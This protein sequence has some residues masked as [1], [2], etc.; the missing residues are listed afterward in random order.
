MYMCVSLYMY[1]YIPVNAVEA[2][3]S[4][5][6]CDGL[7]SEIR[8]AGIRGRDDSSAL[9]LFSGDDKARFYKQRVIR[10][11]HCPLFLSFCASLSVSLSLARACNSSRGT[12]DEPAL[13]SSRESESRFAIDE[14]RI[15]YER[16]LL[17]FRGVRVT[18][19]GKMHFL[20]ACRVGHTSHET[21]DK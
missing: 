3:C 5:R 1:I 15:N 20:Y 17:T 16:T 18:A 7:S 4:R 6:T 11:W 13:K 2:V 9:L 21:R 14:R 12:S 19:T 8:P 10:Y